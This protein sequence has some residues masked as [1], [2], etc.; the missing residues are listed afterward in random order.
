MTDAPPGYN[1]AK[2]YG[3]DSVAGAVI[4]ALLYVPFLLFFVRQ[5]ISRPTYVYIVIALFCAGEFYYTFRIFSAKLPPPSS[6]YCIHFEGSIG[7]CSISRPGPQHS[8]RIRNH[9]QYWF[10]RSA[11]LGI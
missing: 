6:S 8:R 3:I 7:W 2:A 10:L 4:F 9:L 1:F 11:V 5:A